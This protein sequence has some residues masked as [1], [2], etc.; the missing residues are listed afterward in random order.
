MKPLTVIFRI[1][2]VLICFLILFVMGCCGQSLD[3]ALLGGIRAHHADRSAGW[4][5]DNGGIGA[6][7]TLNISKFNVGC[8]YYEFINSYKNKGRVLG[9]S[10]ARMNL[11][12]GPVDIAVAPWLMELH[13][14]QNSKG[15]DIVI[16]TPPWPIF[17]IAVN[18]FD[19]FWIEYNVLWFFNIKIEKVFLKYR[20]RF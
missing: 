6:K 17:E 16:T 13:G 2:I 5:E 4:N 11:E 8:F 3:I 20:A 12:L 1:I 18:I 9:F 15:E 10:P 7:L 19:E 14:Y